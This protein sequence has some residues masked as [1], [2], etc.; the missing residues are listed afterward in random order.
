MPRVGHMPSHSFFVFR[1]KILLDLLA[2]SQTRS[3]LF[4]L[5][6]RSGGIGRRAAFRS[7]WEQS[8][9]GSNPPSG[10]TLSLA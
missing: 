1:P 3:N 2:F 10:T 4:Q 8:R 9:G 6:R 7:Q 5:T